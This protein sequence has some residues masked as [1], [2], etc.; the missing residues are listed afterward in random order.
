M[1]FRFNSSL[2]C[3]HQHRNLNLNGFH[4]VS[5]NL[6]GWRGWCFFGLVVV[7]FFCLICLKVLGVQRCNLWVYEKSPFSNTTSCYPMWENPESTV[8]IYQI[9]CPIRSVGIWIL[10]YCVYKG[11]EKC[12]A[13]NLKVNSVLKVRLSVE[14]SHSVFIVKVRNYYLF[15][16][17]LPAL[18]P[19]FM[20][21]ASRK[22]MVSRIQG[23]CGF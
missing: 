14:K 7:W 16:D 13:C 1:C 11:M 21:E 19:S 9:S 22:G 10:L 12:T 3:S 20:K 17:I 6:L 15:R 8:S 5:F 23:P 4:S 2:G 18:F